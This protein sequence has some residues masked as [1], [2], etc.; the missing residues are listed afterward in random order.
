MQTT[1]ISATFSEFIMHPGGAKILKTIQKLLRLSR[2]D[3]SYSW[4]VL[5]DFGNMSSPTALFGSLGRCTLALGGRTC[6]QHSV[7]ASQPTLLPSTCEP[8][9]RVALAEKVTGGQLTPRSRNLKAAN[10]LLLRRL[11][12][13]R[14]GGLGWLRL[15]LFA[16]ALVSR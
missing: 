14:L 2:G 4:E 8:R 13:R 3:L 15:L 1:C 6:L 9:V 16:R 11:L 12:L 10:F 5:R 7:P